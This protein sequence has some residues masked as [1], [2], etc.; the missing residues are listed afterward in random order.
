MTLPESPSAALQAIFEIGKAEDEAR[1][2]ADELRK[3]RDLMIVEAM[4][5]GDVNK[6]E[7]A[8]GLG[9]RRQWLYQ[10]AEAHKKQLAASLSATA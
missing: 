10:I 4:A 1:R 9:L 5:R 2:H 8:D 3:Q 6:S 7:L